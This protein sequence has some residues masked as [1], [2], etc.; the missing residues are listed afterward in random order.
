LDETRT[1]VA[2][3]P[4]Q[5][6]GQAG[7]SGRKDDHLRINIEH[8][9]SARELTT[10]LERLR[11]VHVALPEHDYNEVD[12]STRFLGLAVRA[13]VLVSSMTGGTARGWEIRERLRETSDEERRNRARVGNQ[14]ETR[15]SRRESRLRD[16]C[17]LTAGRH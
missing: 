11:F 3:K 7:T 1:G 15:E 6:E 13:P 14:P 9:V 4:R 17:W 8:D 12:L 16:G 2:A 10:W 5:D